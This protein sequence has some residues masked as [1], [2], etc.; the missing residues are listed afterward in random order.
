MNLFGD[1]TNHPLGCYGGWIAYTVQR[2]PLVGKMDYSTETQTRVH[3]RPELPSGS[4][5]AVRCFWAIQIKTRRH[6]A[7]LQ[8]LSLLYVGRRC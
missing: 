2:K 4:S 5:G 8:Q 7:D 6:K 3:E 1:N